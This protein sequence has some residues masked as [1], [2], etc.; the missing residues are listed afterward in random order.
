MV[1]QLHGSYR[2]YVFKQTA[3]MILLYLLVTLGISLGMTL[4]GAYSSI[5][6]T[7][8]RLLLQVLRIGLGI[9][10][11]QRLVIVTPR[12]HQIKPLG[13]RLLMP[14]LTVVLLGCLSIIPSSPALTTGPVTWIAHK[15]LNG[16]NGVQNSINVL[17]KTAKAKPDFVEMDVRM[18]K[19]QQ[20]V[21]IHDHSLRP[22]TGKNAH[23]EAYTLAQLEQLHIS[24][25]GYTAPLSSFMAYLAAAKQIHQ[26]LLVEIKT[27][28]S[29][30]SDQVA[31]NFNQRYGQQLLQ[32]G[33]A[34]HSTDPKIVTWFK[35]NQPKLPVGYIVPFTYW[36]IP[37]SSA[38][39]YSIEGSQYNLRVTKQLQKIHKKVY[40]W[41]INDPLALISMLGK[42]P[43]G[44]ITDRFGA[45]K[46]TSKIISVNMGRTFLVWV[47][48]SRPNP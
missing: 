30:N 40:L 41:T 45:L 15:G 28:P 16:T 32:S 21:V 42:A 31:Q 36:G 27:V 14:I 3:K 13:G 24:E 6:M 25:Q 33:G 48:V 10:W 5:A 11:L 34:L 37:K 47:A 46:T 44:I 22:L 23:V 39:F 9:W 26:K 38:D 19:D 29:Q 20:F 43:T 4:L 8:S 17:Q 7:L 2:G 12:E 35:T 18:T 1:D